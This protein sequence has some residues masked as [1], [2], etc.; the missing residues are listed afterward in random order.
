MIRF[1]EIRYLIPGML[2]SQMPSVL[3][4]YVIRHY[5]LSTNLIHLQPGSQY[6]VWN[7]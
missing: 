5:T 7:T 1:S 6:N 4:I 2:I 3:I